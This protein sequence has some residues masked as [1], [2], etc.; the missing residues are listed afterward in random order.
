MRLLSWLFPIDRIRPEDRW[1]VYL[2]WLVGVL[3]GFAQAQAAATVPFTRS[4]L[5]LTE[6]EMSL[7]LAVTRLAGVGAVVFSWWG[8]KKGRRRP[9]LAAYLLLIGA[10]A[11][12]SLVST[13]LAFTG[14]QSLVRLTTAAVG[15][16][17]VVLLAERVEPTVRAFSI[18]LYGAGGSLGA[19]MGLAT[20]PLADLG[21]EGWRIPFGLTAVGFL[22]WP[23]LV[24]RV[25]ESRLYSPDEA[26]RARPLAQLLSSGF[27]ARFW[28]SAAAATLAA[29][30]STV[31]LSFSTERL[32]SDVG[33]PT[34]AAAA[35][36][37]GGGAVGGLGFFV[38]SRLADLIGRRGT[39][40]LAFGCMA[41]G[42]VGV[43]RLD[44][45]A[46][47]GLAIAVSTFGSFAYVPAGASHRVE[48]FPTEFRSTA[49][50]AGSYLAMV[51]SALG[52][53]VGRLTIDRFGLADTVTA[54]ASLLLVSMVL[55]WLLPE[56][57]GQALEAVQPDR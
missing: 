35:L 55:T 18:A 20:L 54:L 51:G 46:L 23:L 21:P 43:Y 26:A 27:A 56:T 19:G 22:A 38:G 25:D 32:V 34:A 9:F 4:T 57:K 24:R 39:T 31:A 47:L 49:G 36:S 45:P 16:L 53:A 8:D 48:L 13:P 42:G 28:L 10:S 6:G 41:V 11:G 14:L 30:F 5:G 33:L 50:A 2:L 52:L 29:A 44:H 12:T 1:T 7:V 37:L 3:Q 15:T 40:I 17:G